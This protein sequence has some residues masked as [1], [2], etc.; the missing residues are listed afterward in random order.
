MSGLLS[1]IFFVVDCA[2]GVFS[3]V[4][5]LTSSLQ[6]HFPQGH[7]SQTHLFGVTGFCNFADGL[8][9]FLE[10]FCVFFFRGLI[11]FG[12]SFRVVALLGLSA[13]HE[14]CFCPMRLER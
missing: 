13:I 14:K 5:F 9:F 11:F 7:C 4:Y 6:R 8:C 3:V 10:S 12:D 1:S 2:Q